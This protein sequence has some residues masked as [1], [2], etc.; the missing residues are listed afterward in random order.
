MNRDF[1]Y[2]Q[3]GV[4]HD[5]GATSG[6]SSSSPYLN[7]SGLREWLT[8]NFLR[9][10]GPDL[11]TPSDPT[12]GLVQA[13]GD[14]RDPAYVQRLIDAEKEAN[15]AFR[16]WV[17]EKWLSELAEE[18]L[19]QYPADSFGARYYAYI[20]EFGI[21]LNFGWKNAPPRSD[22]EFIM[23]RFAQTHDYEHLMTGGGF[24]TIGEL[25][26]YFVR[27]SNPHTH[28][29][30]TLATALG[31]IYLFGGFRLVFRSYLHYPDTW[32]T[33]LDVMRR[34]LEIGRTSEPFI[35]MRYEDA[36]GLSIDDAREMLG[37]RNAVDLDTAAISAAFDDMPDP[38]AQP[39]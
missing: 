34:G 13:L 25:L 6:L 32:T 3:R 27:L 30:P 24:N 23:M 31:E 17:E 33:V 18:D 22:F 14:I 4:R 16:Q 20:R 19:A 12:R 28:L 21:K 10:N 35:L 2:F 1:S 26:P 5:L 36:L 39:I 38:H 15:P 7:H 29:S 9:R 8:T 11:P 37:V